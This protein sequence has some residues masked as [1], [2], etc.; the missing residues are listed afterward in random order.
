MATRKDDLLFSL[1]QVRQKILAEI[2]TL[3]ETQRERVFLGVWSVKDLLAHFAGWD[4]TNLLAVKRVRK[5]Q[6]PSFY[7]HRDRDWQTYN[8]TLVKKYKK[9]S[10][11]EL[12]AVVKDSHEK[13]IEFLKTIPPEDFHRDFGVR[14]RGYK[15]TIQRL[16]EA[17]TRDEQTHHQQII[18]F[19]KISK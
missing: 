5:G 7:K 2:S 14:F 17:E 15:V 6:V 16:L 4:T 11:D 13:L 8:A 9:G 18:V 3:S 10:F 19:F 1:V 12:L